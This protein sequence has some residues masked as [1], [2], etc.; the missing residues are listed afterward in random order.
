EVAYRQALAAPDPPAAQ[1]LHAR[2]HLALGSL[3]E[4]QGEYHAAL[5]VL[6]HA[7]LAFARLEDRAGLGQVLGQIG[8]VYWMQIDYPRARTYYEQWLAIATALG[9]Q[10]EQARAL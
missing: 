10:A 2:L 3:L 1:D 4:L 7:C 8:R 5:A 9:D 6:E